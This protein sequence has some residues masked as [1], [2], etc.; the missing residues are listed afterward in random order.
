MAITKMQLF[1]DDSLSGQKLGR[2]VYHDARSWLFPAPMSAD[3]K[4]VRHERSVPIFDQAHVGSCT[5]NAAIGC[6]ST[7]PFGHQGNEAEAVEVYGAATHIDRIKGVY[8]AED[9]GSSG[10]AVM[11]VLKKRKLIEGYAH[12]FGLTNTLRALVLG[13]G[14]TGIAWRE[15][16]DRPNSKG[17]VRYIGAVRGGHEVELVGIDADEKLVWFANSWGK[18]WGRDGYFA[19]SFDDYG[20][21][22]A[23]HGDATFPALPNQG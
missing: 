14:I 7:R 20:L 21:A 18:L 16:C 22:L 13:P 6:I 15:G 19:M 10:L 11:K 17:I 12:G 1:V 8:P 5:G 9:T 2:H 4:S 23:D 3:I